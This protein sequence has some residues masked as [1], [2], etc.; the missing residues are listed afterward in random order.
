MARLPTPGSDDGEWGEI[1]NEY[2]LQAHTS[3]GLIK[4]GVVTLGN[5]APTVQS[6]ISASIGATGPT[7]ASG[8]QGIQGVTGPS[9]PVGSVGPT[10]PQGPQGVPGPT[11]ATGPAAEIDSDE[12]ASLYT[13]FVIV[14]TGSEP[15]PGPAG[16]VVL[17]LDTRNESND[18]AN[19]AAT[20]IR[21]VAG[22]VTPTTAPAI[23]T[24][25]LGTITEGSAYSVALAATGTAPITWTVASG[26]L[27]DG[28]SLS[29]AG[30]LSGTPTMQGVYDFTVQATNAAGNDTRQYT[31]SVQ[32]SVT[33]ETY[34][35]NYTNRTALLAD[36]WYFYAQLP[37]GNGARNTEAPG[38]LGYS[39]D[40]LQILA[41]EWSIY[42]PSSNS[43]ENMLF[44]SLPAGWT[45]VELALDFTPLGNHDT[46]GI[47]IYQDDDNYVQFTKSFT[48]GTMQ[49]AYL[50]R[51]AAGQVFDEQYPLYNPT[52]IVLRI[53]K[54][55]DTYTAKISSN[56]GA[57]WTTIGTVTQ[58][59][60]APVFGIYTGASTTGSPYAVST[61][62]RVSFEA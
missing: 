59:L 49:I 1:L 48:G 30:L 62:K 18:P 41:R 40:G 23:T 57:T 33:G 6:Q 45:A 15:R 14:A 39:L 43:A 13:R 47:V 12:L 50:Y 11:G 19:M 55:A 9:G 4:P 51:E 7:G 44:H 42:G 34:I 36:D 20:D 10:G 2:L 37:H 17:W 25:S 21:F 58:S 16:G 5:L 26:A 38:Y 29:S 61:I 35:F 56:N 54:S 60:D 52:D 27:P 28:L 32:A 8:A 24:G 22:T 53:E 3:D 46:S 31:G